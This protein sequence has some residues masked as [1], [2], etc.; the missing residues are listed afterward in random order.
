MKTS[1]ITTATWGLLGLFSA[2]AMTAKATTQQQAKIHE[3]GYTFKVSRYDH[4]RSRPYRVFFWDDH[5][6]GSSYR[7]DADGHV[8]YFKAGSE[9]YYD[10]TEMGDYSLDFK[11]KREGS[12]MTTVGKESDDEELP[13]LNCDECSVAL[14]AVCDSGLPTFCEKVKESILGSDGKKSVD[15]LCANQ[16]GACAK[17]EA[18]CEGVCAAEKGE[19]RRRVLA[20]EVVAVGH[21]R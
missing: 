5:L 21:R 8:R 18:A 2:S 14:A 20:T 9:V 1:T 4:G 16:E 3:G 13:G 10:R 17:G 11:K 12:R 7:L 19:D 15:I 6:T